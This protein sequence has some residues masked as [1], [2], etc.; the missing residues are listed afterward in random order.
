MGS[1]MSKIVTGL[2]VGNFRDAKDQKQLTENMITHILAIHDDAKKLHEDKEYLCIKASDSPDQDLTQ[3]FHECI[4]FIHSARVQNKGVLVHCLA[5]VSRSVTITAAYIMTISTLG[6]RDAL[7]AIRGARNVANPNFGFQKQ[8]Q[9]FQVEKLEEERKAIRQKYSNYEYDDERE[10]RQNIESY[11]RFV[12]YGDSRERG[13]DNMLK[14]DGE[15]V[16]DGM[17]RDDSK[18]LSFP[19]N[20]YTSDRDKVKEREDKGTG[21]DDKEDNSGN[22]KGDDS[23][24]IDAKIGSQIDG[25]GKFETV[26]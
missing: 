16:D 25:D 24:K 14:D 26:L 23:G 2:Y 5:G 21:S 3:Y 18:L 7:N 12:V 13:E 6:W 20:A 10:L 11:R 22:S 1:G 4:E 19:Y 8:L 9:R 17:L 15:R